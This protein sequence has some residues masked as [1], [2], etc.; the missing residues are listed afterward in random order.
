[1]TQFIGMNKLQKVALKVIAKNLPE[2][3]IMGLKQMFKR[4]DT[5][6]NNTIT[7]DELNIGFARQG[8]KLYDTEARQLMEVVRSLNSLLVFA[9]MFE[10]FN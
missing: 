2:E 8:S 3:D 6:N 7:F 5:N 9:F 10:S 4:M 1:M